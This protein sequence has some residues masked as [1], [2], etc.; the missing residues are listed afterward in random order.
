M[1]A[2]WHPPADVAATDLEYFV[3]N[4]HA[5]HRFR[6]TAKVHRG[7]PVIVIATV[8]RDDTGRPIS[9]F[10]SLYRYDGGHA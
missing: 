4:P 8:T 9:T 7:W 2:P 10:R 5:R 1:T 6:A 3:A